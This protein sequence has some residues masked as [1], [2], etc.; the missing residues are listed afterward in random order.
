VDGESQGVGAWGEV[1]VDEDLPRFGP[2]FGGVGGEVDLDLLLAWC[3][4][5]PRGILDREHQANEAVGALV[6]GQQRQSANGHAH[7]G[8]RARRRRGECELGL[9]WVA[10]GA[11]EQPGQ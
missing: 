3:P 5:E 9:Q 11:E 6:R 10:V 1:E 7:G 4:P 2:G 8:A